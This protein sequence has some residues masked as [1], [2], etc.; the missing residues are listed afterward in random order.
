MLDKEAVHEK[1]KRGA[2]AVRDGL[3]EDI[4]WVRLE[5][6]SPLDEVS[7]AERFGVSRTPVR[8]ALLLL[9]GERLVQFLPNRT[10]VVAPF[11]LDNVGD[12]IDTFLLLS[13]AAARSA[14]VSGDADIEKLN[15]LTAKHHQAVEDDDLITMFESDK[16]L[17]ATIADTCGNIFQSSYFNQALMAGHRSRVLCYYPNATKDDLMQ[18]NGLMKRLCD[19]IADGNVQSSDETMTALV[20]QDFEII[21]RSIQPSVTAEMDLS[22]H[23]VRLGVKQ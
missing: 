13:R 4:L 3:R 17:R 1:K 22:G 14:A 15:A 2:L 9:S 5:P 21:Q 23:P 18:A 8:E 7:L 11:K 20:M 10:T 19:D 12:L 6:G 16:E